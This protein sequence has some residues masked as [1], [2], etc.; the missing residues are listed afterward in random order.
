MDLSIQNKISTLLQ[1]AYCA[2]KIS[3]GESVIIK[4][5]T[6]QIKVIVLALDVAPSQEKKYL[7]KAQ[8][9]NVEVIRYLSKS[10]LGALFSKQDV[11]CVGVS[12]N[13]MANQIKKLSK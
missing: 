1:F 8:H 4:M 6:G 5:M 2:K 3:F 9:Y 13:N 11:A 7:D 10:D 12:D